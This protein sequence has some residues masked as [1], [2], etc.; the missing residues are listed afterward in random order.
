[1]RPAN[2]SR[3]SVFS[4]DAESGGNSCAT[5]ASRRRVGPH[6]TSAR[7]RSVPARLKGIELGTATQIAT[8]PQEPVAARSEV[9]G[10][11]ARIDLRSRHLDWV[12]PGLS[13]LDGRGWFRCRCGRALRR[14][15]R[16]TGRL[17][18]ARVGGSE[19]CRSRAGLC[20]SPHRSLAFKSRR[21]PIRPPLVRRF[22][23]TLPFSGGLAVAP[24]AYRLSAQGLWMSNVIRCPG[25]PDPGLGIKAAA[26]GGVCT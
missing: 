4:W 11:A 9:W 16:W 2:P 18:G 12:A 13:W 22:G 20:R 26:G 3:G 1:M 5:R 15:H 6:Q 14:R 10:P 21:S 8:F 19:R 7:E 25:R 17:V 24:C 23:V